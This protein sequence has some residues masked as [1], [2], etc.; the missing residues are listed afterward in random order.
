MRHI[1][2]SGLKINGK[3]NAITVVITTVVLAILFVLATAT[4]SATPSD[5]TGTDHDLGSAGQATC[6][7]C[8]IPHNANGSALWAMTPKIGMTGMQSLCFSCHDG[9]V[10]AKGTYIG[11][12]SYYTH[13]VSP[14]GNLNC[15]NCHSAH[16]P[17]GQD[18]KGLTSS[19]AH[20][21][22]RDC[23]R[24]HDPHSN[25]WRFIKADLEQ[26]ADVC[27]SCHSNYSNNHP[28]DMASDSYLPA[29]RLWDPYAGTPDFS[30][31]R[32]WDAIGTTVDNE[33]TGGIK[34]LTCHATHGALTTMLN[35]VEYEDPQSSSSPIC[36]NCH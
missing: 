4:A 2:I 13:P 20:A 10:S 32:L 11:D 21:A 6:G 15:S 8:H 12:L 16:G 33:G 3:K 7:Y 9:T 30:G 36:E 29:D 5:V 34:C 1:I 24:C 14:E 18:R 17:D 19:A 22:N 35:S 26:S 31:T 27:I 28:V 23:D 25:S